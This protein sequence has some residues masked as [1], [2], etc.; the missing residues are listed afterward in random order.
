MPQPAR[1]GAFYCL[2]RGAR[3]RRRDAGSAE[4]ARR[5]HEIDIAL[6]F[7]EAASVWRPGND[8]EAR[9]AYASANLS[10]GG[11]TRVTE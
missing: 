5:D 1:G 9:R 4:I 7:F 8:R 6:D 3:S 2:H 10:F 11:R